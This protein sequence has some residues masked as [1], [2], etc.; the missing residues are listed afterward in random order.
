MK[1]LDYITE[2]EQE[3]SIVVLRDAVDRIKSKPLTK[4]QEEKVRE[5]ACELFWATMEENK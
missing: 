5:Y 1:S 4:E 3:L 2:R